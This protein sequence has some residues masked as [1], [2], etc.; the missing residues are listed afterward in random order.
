MEK[1]WAKWN[2]RNRERQN[3]A[4]ESPLLNEGNPY[5]GKHIN[6]EQSAVK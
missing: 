5:N 1:K 6:Y 4:R 2:D 3:R